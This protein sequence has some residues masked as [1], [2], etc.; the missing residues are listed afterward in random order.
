MTHSMYLIL[1]GSGI[2]GL[3]GIIITY[4][5]MHK[6][7]TKKM[8]HQEI[9]QF[10]RRMRRLKGNGKVDIME[11]SIK[12][13]A[14]KCLSFYYGSFED[15]NSKNYDAIGHFIRIYD[16]QKYYSIQDDGLGNAY[17]TIQTYRKNIS[18]EEIQNKIC[19]NLRLI[20]A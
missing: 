1:I 9:V 18:E 3:I 17:T 4:I 5:V 7:F 20:I 11:R 12:R 15:F 13:F 10:I 6:R 16:S 8:Q 14:R 19:E 2:G